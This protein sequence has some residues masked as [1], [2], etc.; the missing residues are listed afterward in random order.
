MAAA[1]YNIE[2]E[3]GADWS[4]IF[5]KKNST[6]LVPFDLTGCTARMHIREEI[7]AA[8]ILDTLTTENGRIVLVN[9][10]NPLGGVVLGGVKLIFPNAVSTAYVDWDAGVYQLELI[11]PSGIVERMLKGTVTLSAEV[12]R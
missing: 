2:I 11:Y 4:R 3:R 12:T 6:T 9:R 10:N 7:G 1:K 8:T 5:T